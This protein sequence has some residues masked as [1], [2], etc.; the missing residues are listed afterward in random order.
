MPTL[1]RKNTGQPLPWELPDVNWEYQW[2]IR[3]MLA[4]RWNHYV[5]RYL[6]SH[7][8]WPWVISTPLV[9]V[10]STLESTQNWVSTNKIFCAKGGRGVDFIEVNSMLLWGDTRRYISTTRWGYQRWHQKSQQVGSRSCR[11]GWLPQA[12]CT[13]RRWYH[14]ICV[15]YIGCK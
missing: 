5:L 14:N 12:Y 7:S 4:V 2:I 6:V 10:P 1:R 8:G 11:H 13:W 15:S 3:H 9:N